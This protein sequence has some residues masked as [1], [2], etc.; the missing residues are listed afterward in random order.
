MKTCI[1]C[2]ADISNRGNRSFLCSDCQKNHRKQYQKRY[3][4]QFPSAARG[5]YRFYFN[6]VAKLTLDELSALFQAKRIAIGLARTYQ[7]YQSLQAQMQI[8]NDMYNRKKPKAYP[9]IEEVNDNDK[10]TKEAEE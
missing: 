7:E 8:I 4:K 5:K 10:C 9:T 2:G 6:H 1:S 3:N